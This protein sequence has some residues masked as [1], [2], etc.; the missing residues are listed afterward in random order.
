MRYADWFWRLRFKIARLIMPK[1][2]S[3]INSAVL[4]QLQAEAP[5]S[6]W[7]APIEYM[8]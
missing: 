2:Y 4:R 8:H 7:R 1:E 3:L 5:Q 6:C